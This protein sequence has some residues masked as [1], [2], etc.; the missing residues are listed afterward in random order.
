MK[1]THIR[2]SKANLALTRP[3]TIAYHTTDAVEN[4]LVILETDTEEI[5]IG[6]SS[7]AKDVIGESVDEALAVLSVADFSWLI[8][9]E[10]KYFH[11]LCHEVYQ[12]FP[13]SIG[14]QAALD[15]AL[16]D[17]YAKFLD[18]PL[19]AIW[20]QK[21]QSL[22][23]SVTIGI[24]GMKE[25]IEEAEEYLE[26]GFK[27]LKVK[28]GLN[29][30]EDIE[31]LTKLRKWV[32]R[33]IK[34]RIDPNQGYSKAQFLDFYERTKK[35]G[36]ELIEQ[37]MPARSIDEMR[38]LP[39]PIRRNIA[40][41]ESLTNE[42]SAFKIAQKPLPCGI[43]NIK[44]MK[45]GGLTEAKKIMQVAQRASMKL[46]WGCNDESVVSIAAALH[47][48]FSSPLTHYI[49]LDGSFDLAKDLAE[50]GFILKNGIMSLTT[51]KGL[52]VR[53]L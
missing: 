42:L 22:P 39:D 27:I 38:S 9:K 23:T 43:F 19:V 45:T 16:H 36:L 28:L 25:T 44:L 33:R 40:L 34:I 15:I 17:L 1:I 51:Q 49:D 12:H 53:L 3:Y 35:L 50:G 37:P 20:G 4:I 26:S 32:G 29:V 8:G 2:I 24:K 6:T 5:G 47:L 46:M 11:Q 52:G 10:I 41:D 13:Q 48:A 7:P 30:E 18:K 31:R 21:I 14:S